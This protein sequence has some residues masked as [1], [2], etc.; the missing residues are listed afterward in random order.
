MPRTMGCGGGT[1]TEKRVK[2]VVR[3]VRR[4]RSQER[5]ERV[6]EVGREWRS[7]CD[8]C[9]EKER[10]QRRASATAIQ[11]QKCFQVAY[12]HHLGITLVRD[13]QV[14]ILDQLER[15]RRVRADHEREVRATDTA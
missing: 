11:R 9:G 5:T 12:L 1:G 10:N 7:P 13:P 4:E 15:D 2:V 6:A 3:R 8:P 14:D